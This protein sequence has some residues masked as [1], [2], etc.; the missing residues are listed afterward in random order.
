MPEKPQGEQIMVRVITISSKRISDR[1]MGLVTSMIAASLLS[2]CSLTS[3]GGGSSVIARAQKDHA[4]CQE[5][6]QRFP[7]QDYTWCRQSLQDERERRILRGRALVDPDES[8]IGVDDPL[9]RP[10]TRRGDFRCEERRTGETRWIDC[11]V[12][13]ER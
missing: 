3:D 5:E 1:G 6:G 7:S 9:F 13:Q 10:T 8:G 2:A 4:I 11:R 12:I